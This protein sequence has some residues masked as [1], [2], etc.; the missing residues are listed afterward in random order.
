M[1]QTAA[2]EFAP[3]NILIDCVCPGSVDTRLTEFQREAYAQVYDTSPQELKDE[4]T[5]RIAMGRW[6]L[7]EDRA[8]AVCFLVSPVNTYITAQALPVE[9]G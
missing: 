6:A 9:G 1:T 5:R 3:H 4:Q 8:N 2:F 7:G